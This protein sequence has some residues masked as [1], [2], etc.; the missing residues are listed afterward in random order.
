MK[1]HAYHINWQSQRELV[2]LI[3]FATGRVSYH[4]QAK[5]LYSFR[6]F[7]LFFKIE[8]L[9]ESGLSNVRIHRHL[10]RPCG[11]C[12][13]CCTSR[14]KCTGAIHCSDICDH[15]VRRKELL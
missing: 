3:G 7:L 10:T 15:V 14:V 11:C 8:I 1:F 9:W 2:F 6:L 12:H 4:P 5:W 13:S